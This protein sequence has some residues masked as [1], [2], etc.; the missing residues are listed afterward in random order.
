MG[1]LA[2]LAAVVRAPHQTTQ[3]AARDGEGLAG[4]ALAAPRGGVL[5][6]GVAAG[7]ALARAGLAPGDLVVGWRR[8]DAGPSSAPATGEIAT[9]FDWLWL[10]TEEAPRGALR[11]TVERRDKVA[12]IAVERGS[13]DVQVL[14]WL[15]P[16]LAVRARASRDLEKAPT[17]G[18][19]AA[20]WETLAAGRWASRSSAARCWLLLQASQDWTAAGQ[21]A[22]AG[23]DLDLALRLAHGSRARVAVLRGA[24][25]ALADRSDLTP[26]ADLAER[27]RQTAVAAW[28]ESLEL[29]QADLDRGAVALAQGQLA[30]AD[31][32]W[33]L[34]LVLRERLAPGSP[35]VAA[36]LVRL[37]GT[38][39]SRG[40]LDR[41][42][43]LAS[44]ALDILKPLR[45]P[46]LEAAPLMVLGG[47]ARERGDEDQAARLLRLALER[48][49]E[50]AP[51]ST[52]AEIL[53]RL[54]TVARRRGDLGAAQQRFE[55]ALALWG[56]FAPAGLERTNVLLNLGW[57]AADRGD[58]AAARGR[59]EQAVAARERLQPGSM[60]LASSLGQLA[61]VVEDQGDL[62]LAE[63]LLQRELSILA[64][65]A[66]DSMSAAMAM[67]NLGDLALRGGAWDR[68]ADL[69]ARAISIQERVAPGNPAVAGNLETLAEA[70]LARRHFGAA[71]SAASRAE[72]LASHGGGRARASTLAVLGEVAR[73]RGEPGRATGL[74]ERALALQER[75][76]YGGYEVADVLH[77]LGTLS[78]RRRPAVAARYFDRAIAMLEEQIRHLGGSRDLQA[79][80]RGRHQSFYRDAIEL[81]VERRRFV[82]AFG[83]PE[84]S[85]GQALLAQLAERDITFAR[86]VSPALRTEE[87]G[88]AVA[89]D[90]TEIRVL[91]LE[92]LGDSA[93]LRLVRGHLD[94]LHRSHDDVVARIRQASPRYAALVHPA[95][96]DLAGVRR[97]LDPQTVMLS[98]SL[99]ER[100]TTLFVAASTGPLEV[101]RLAAGEEELRRRVA[102]L[103]GLIG[104]VP[105][106]S[107]LGRGKR[108]ALL[109]AAR[110]LYGILVLPAARRIAAS[111]RLLVVPDGILHQL[112]WGALV[113]DAPAASAK[114][115]EYVAEWRPIH[116]AVS[117]T[118]YDDL[119]RLRPAAAGGAGGAT[120]A[121]V[122]TTASTARTAMTSTRPGAASLVAFADPQVPAWLS[123][124]SPRRPA[125]R[126]LR[127]AVE[128]GCSFA[129]LPYA[130]QEVTGIAGLFPAGSQVYL[131]AAATEERAKAVSRRVRYLH[132]ATHTTLDESSPLD[133]AV[134][135][136]IPERLARGSE[137][138]LLQA[139]EI[140]DGMRLDADLVVLSGC[141]SALGREVEGEGLMGLTR[142]FQYAGARAVLASL[143]N[144]SDRMTAPLMVSFYRALLAGKSSDEALRQAQMEMLHGSGQS[145][146]AAGGAA[147]DPAPFLWAGFELFGDWR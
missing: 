17:A 116:V 9:V 100:T 61:L 104:E 78:R 50:S 128:R 110:E 83:L 48:H 44:R 105:S 138:G 79:N 63:K 126:G 6:S 71:W 23:A 54:G 82:E 129:P 29:A 7:S 37:A 35:E 41:A 72:M 132:F 107:I 39:L 13:W 53:N 64:R 19:A 75:Q 77:V 51:D 102:E 101:Y 108:A 134:V 40:D 43:A 4:G 127:S 18:A 112:P 114:G 10:V 147:E 30:R 103:R 34:C 58:L 109:R 93:Q 141:E 133:S 80:Y 84:R 106:A 5:V 74:F 67:G 2:V 137:N 69:C 57:V 88:I 143:W 38:A 86:D 11:L 131:G 146:P 121:T 60:P 47:V 97:A 21:A 99:G 119:R 36:V 118:V 16:A 45:A 96:L 1:L 28:G 70:E 27:A 81:A 115:W 56:R 66:P 49:P 85:R 62:E 87:R 55:H 120:T 89:I 26:A 31:E 136:A 140:F 94:E 73:Q 117:A 113:R 139:W 65:I 42:G 130:R 144:V 125:D 142:A 14:P 95:P 98:Y 52:T 33:G 122:A 8:A 145:N 20:G 90:Q 15:P 111:R 68:A 76:G 135:L 123:A 91:Q 32:A 25:G 124:S 59:M 22:R 24:A 12:E 3:T 46:G 92:R